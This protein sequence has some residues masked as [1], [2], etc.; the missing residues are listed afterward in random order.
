MINI[1]RTAFPYLTS[2]SAL[3]CVT[4]I[5]FFK[6]INELITYF[7]RNPDEEQGKVSSNKNEYNKILKGIA[8]MGIS[9]ASAY[10]FYRIQKSFFD[11]NPLLVSVNTDLQMIQADQEE[12]QSQ[13]KTQIK[14]RISLRNLCLA[15]LKSAEA[16]V[17]IASKQPTRS[18]TWFADTLPS[19]ALSGENA[20]QRV[21]REFQII[22]EDLKR[23]IRSLDTQFLKFK[24]SIQN[25]P[26]GKGV[27]I[28][29][30]VLCRSPFSFLGGQFCSKYQMFNKYSITYEHL[31]TKVEHYKD[32]ILDIHPYNRCHK[33]FD[34]HKKVQKIPN[35]NDLENLTE[36]S[37]L[38]YIIQ[39]ISQ[40]LNLDK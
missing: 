29:L 5:T 22:L 16:Y 1:E 11:V 37:Y 14:E 20:V 34:I 8:W 36:P 15:H 33:A 40:Y 31:L 4:T 27:H 23:R 17:S 21:Q 10:G 13:Y 39:S 32:D 12:F 30:D 2:A 18:Y 6:G 19:I 3:S 25:Y 35:Q 24:E 26:L 9:L 38:S 28:N 7:N